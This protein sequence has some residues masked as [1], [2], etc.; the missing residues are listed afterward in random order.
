[1]S[2]RNVSTFKPE[3]CESVIAHC[4]QGGTIASFA[5]VLGIAK[6]TVYN[7]R[8]QYPEF[9]LACEVGIGRA[10]F[11]DEKVLHHL[12]TVGDRDKRLG[13][14]LYRLGNRAPDVWR[15]VQKT[16]VSG[17]DGGPV[18]TTFTIVTG[19]PRADADS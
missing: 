2:P 3:Y 10:V 6:Q 16:E 15:N 9:D 14:V 1:M 4:A 8:K 19:V 11:E 5:A 7:W 18:A 13:P 17:P 12:V